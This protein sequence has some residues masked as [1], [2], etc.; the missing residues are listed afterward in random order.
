MIK[1]GCLEGVDEVKGFH[2]W[3]TAPLG[4]LWRQPGPVMS[5]ITILEIKIHGTGGHASEPEKCKFSVRAAVKFYQQA[6]D[7]LDN[8]LKEKPNKFVCTLPIFQSGERLNVIS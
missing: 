5:E 7:Y 2:Q 1:D 8:L 4:E 3:P 6:L